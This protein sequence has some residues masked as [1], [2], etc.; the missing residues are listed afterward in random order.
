[1]NKCLAEAH[2]QKI[3]NLDF[4]VPATVKP[5]HDVGTESVTEMIYVVVFCFGLLFQYCE[6]LEWD[7]LQERTKNMKAASK[8]M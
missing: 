5:I 1:M 2:M 8:C 7:F 4:C 6:H 3:R